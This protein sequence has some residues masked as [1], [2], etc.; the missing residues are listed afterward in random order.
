[1]NFTFKLPLLVGIQETNQE[2]IQLILAEI[3]TV[4]N[5]IFVA[6]A[7]GIK[8]RVA[9]LIRKYI[10][11]SPEFK[12]LENGVLK[13]DL[14]LA[15]PSSVLI[16]IVNALANEVFVIINP[17]QIKGNRLVGGIKV[18]LI[19]G[20]YSKI[21]GM[22]EASYI[23]Q[24]LLS[25]QQHQIDWLEWLVKRGDSI[26]I[27]DHSVRYTTHWPSRSGG[28]IMFKSRKGF[29]IRPQFSGT[30]D[31]NFITRAFTDTDF[32][33]ALV[34]EFEAEITSHY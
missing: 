9:G 17:L 23:S 19:K 24:G 13:I 7:P 29:R 1:M 20:D 6:S 28:G 12:S 27:S 14:G 26:I 4:L 30:I 2:I 11:D 25:Q 31:N 32:H 22:P 3:A 18:Q 34:R 15:S 5:P 10:T 33:D 8:V 21:L 16:P